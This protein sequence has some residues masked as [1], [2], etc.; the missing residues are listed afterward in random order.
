MA[1]LSTADSLKDNKLVEF[2]HFHSCCKNNTESICAYFECVHEHILNAHYFR[3]IRIIDS[4]LKW[5]KNLVGGAVYDRLLGT[6][7][8]RVLMHQPSTHT[9]LRH[10]ETHMTVS[11]HDCSVALF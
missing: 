6:P 9:K 5:K 4:L 10:S 3:R 2:L 8:V 11:F 7:I 1:E